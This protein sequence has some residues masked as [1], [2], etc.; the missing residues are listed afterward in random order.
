M[1]VTRAQQINNPSAIKD[2]VEELQ[3]MGYPYVEMYLDVALMTY[4]INGELTCPH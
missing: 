2:A 4:R 3:K 1:Q